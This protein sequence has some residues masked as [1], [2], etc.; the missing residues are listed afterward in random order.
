MKACYCI[1]Y[2]NLAARDCRLRAMVE[3]QEDQEVVFVAC[4]FV[5][6]VSSYFSLRALS[7][8]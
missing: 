5:F 6:F 1:S 8:Y 7:V 2:L 4:V 3:K